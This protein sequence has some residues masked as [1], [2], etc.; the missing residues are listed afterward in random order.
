VGTTI[1]GGS[2]AAGASPK[3]PGTTCPAAPSRFTSHTPSTGDVAGSLHMTG[4]G[5]SDGPNFINDLRKD[6]T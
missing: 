4:L 3:P 1:A 2:G 6:M 5:T